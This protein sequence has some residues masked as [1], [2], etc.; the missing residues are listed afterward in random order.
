MEDAVEKALRPD[1]LY[2]PNLVDRGEVKRYDPRMGRRKIP[3]NFQMGRGFEIQPPP[4]VPQYAPAH[5]VFLQ[6][7]IDHLLAIR[8]MSNLAKANQIP[9]A[10]SIDRILEMAGPIVTDISR[11]MERSLR[12][13]GEMV[14]CLFYEF[15]T[16]PRKVKVMGASGLEEH[17]FVFDPEAL[18]PSQMKSTTY[19][20]EIVPQNIARARASINNCIFHITPNSLHQIQQMTR[21]LLYLQLWRDGRFPIDPET[22]AEALDIPNF[23]T[24]PGDN[25]DVLTRWKEWNKLMMQTQIEAQM[26]AQAAQLQMQMEAQAAGLGMIGG[27][28]AADAQQNGGA[29][30]GKPNGQAHEGRPPSAQKPP[31]LENKGDRST[32]SES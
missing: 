15:Y 7:E 4:E 20:N 23:G 1:V 21:K 17:D 28:A 32:I 25:T 19:A 16:T 11:G 12:D 14:K 9:S 3:V 31:H 8:D 10:E 18:I 29:A 26:Q 5:L 24:L 27:Q 22:V 13:L 6:Q 30:N 2:D